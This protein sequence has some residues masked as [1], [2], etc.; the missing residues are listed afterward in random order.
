MRDTTA[1]SDR[2]TESPV[3][4]SVVAAPVLIP[5]LTVFEELGRGAYAVVHRAR[6]HGV[7]YALKVLP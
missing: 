4:S 6:R 7:D 1:A 3:A 2:V 5:G